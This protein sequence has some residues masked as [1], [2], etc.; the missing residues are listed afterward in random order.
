MCVKESVFPFN[1][2]P[3]VDT[4]LG[5]EM[6]STGE[7]MGIDATVGK[8]Y[9]K[10]QISAGQVIPKDGR[11]FLS[12]KDIDKDKL[13][14]IAPLIIDM[15]FTIVATKGTQEFLNRNGIECDVIYKVNEGRP[16]VVDELKNESIQM[17]INSPSNQISRFDDKIIR[18][19]SYKL[20]IPVITTMAGAKSTIEA[21]SEVAKTELGVTSLQEYYEH[22]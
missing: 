18:Q 16:N 22:L 3:G 19:E 5:P 21:M 8:A 1:R 2:F 15:G 9:L 11:I 12:V 10:S 7:V 4:L 13:L 14:M 17:V 6:R 20:N